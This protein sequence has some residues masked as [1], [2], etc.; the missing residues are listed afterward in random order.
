VRH[1]L[2]RA[3]SAVLDLLLPL[4]CAGCAAPATAWCQRCASALGGL[5]RIHRPLVV[6]GPPMYALG[7][8]RAAARRAVLAYKESGRRQLAAPL[9]RQLA[10]GLVGLAPRLRLGPG[11][12][13]VPAPSRAVAA[14]R[15]GGSH[16]TRLARQ[17]AAELP[18]WELRVADCLR[19]AHRA[20]DSA[21]L[22]PQQ[23]LRNLAG[24]VRLRPG[25]LPA[26]PVEAV[27]LDDVITTGATV[28][29]CS[30][31]LRT[32][33]VRVRAVLSLTATAGPRG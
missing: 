16:M 13:L 14:R 25:R 8:Y 10:V 20:A 23:R 19:I 11:T 28:A 32:T 3:G 9:A 27:L 15:R 21:A 6:D 7:A 26:R 29:S 30:R 22:D 1:L 2:G 31:A 12:L 5:H 17:L 24:N 18:D 33:P 4:H